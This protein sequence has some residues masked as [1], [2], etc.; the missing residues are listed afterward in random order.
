[1]RPRKAKVSETPDNAG[2]KTKDKEKKDKEKD[3]EKEKEEKPKVKTGVN[4][5][6]T[7]EKSSEPILPKPSLP[8][9]IPLFP[10]FGEDKVNY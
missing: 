3:K 2:A 4:I 1:M 5:K 7:D 8:C 10:L 9:K 6:C